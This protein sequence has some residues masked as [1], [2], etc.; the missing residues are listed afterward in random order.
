MWSYCN[1]ISLRVNAI[2]HEIIMPPQIH[3]WEWWKKKIG[4]EDCMYLWRC[5][6]GISFAVMSVPNLAACYKMKKKGGGG[7]CI[8]AM[9]A[10]EQSSC[11]PTT[12]LSLVLYSVFNCKLQ[13]CV[14]LLPFCYTTLILFSCEILLLM[15]YVL[16][17]LSFIVNSVAVVSNIS[18]KVFVI[19]FHKN[20]GILSVDI[21]YLCEVWNGLH[22]AHAP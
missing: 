16:H 12:S 21:Q 3:P 15:S 11:W 18:Y 1:I 19:E 2:F 10:P 22:C 20:Y 4:I 9:H 14:F 7:C 13:G 17:V 8:V 5:Y 6:S